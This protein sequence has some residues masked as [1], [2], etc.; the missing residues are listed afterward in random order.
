MFEEVVFFSNMDKDVY[1]QIAALAGHK[2]NK[3]I[4]NDT[5]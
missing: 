5:I 2:N 1:Y 4:K 3:D